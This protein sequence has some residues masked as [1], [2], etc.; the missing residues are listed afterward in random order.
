MDRPTTEQIATARA[1]AGLTQSAAGALV[2]VSVNQWQK[3]E[4]G[5]ARM[6][7]AMWELFL[8]KTG[9]ISTQIPNFTHR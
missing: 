8:I 5:K 7:P 1:K 3:W 9:N 6:H 4:Y 2:H